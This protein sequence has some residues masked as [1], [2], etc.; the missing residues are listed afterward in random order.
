M[1]LTWQEKLILA[2]IVAAVATSVVRDH[3]AREEVQALVSL[4][5]CRLAHHYVDGGMCSGRRCGLDRGSA[6]DDVRQP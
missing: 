4:T 3:A 6:V 1:S 5:P 2:V